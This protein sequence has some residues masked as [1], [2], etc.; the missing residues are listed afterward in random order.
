[1]DETSLARLGIKQ[2]P[3]TADAPESA[4][5][6]EYVARVERALAP[7]LENR[8]QTLVLSYAQDAGSLAVLGRVLS[9]LDEQRHLCARLERWPDAQAPMLQQLL[10]EWGLEA[11][12]HSSITELRALFELFV[13]HQAAKGRSCHLAGPVAGEP[14]D[15]VRQLLEW[16]SALRHGGEFSVRLLLFGEGEIPAHLRGTPTEN[17]P[18][19]RTASVQFPALGPEEARHYLHTRLEIAGCA[20]ADELIDDELCRLAGAYAS[21]RP[22]TL[23]RLLEGAL[24]ALATEAD[25]TRITQSDLE[26]AATRLGLELVTETLTSDTSPQ[27]ALDIGEAQL[28]M[29]LK[30]EP[31]SEIALNQSRMVMGREQDCDIC[32]ESRFISRFQCL[33]MLTRRGWYVMDLGSTNGTYVNARRIR[34]HLLR[35]GDMITIGRHQIL[36]RQAGAGARGGEEG[37]YLSTEVLAGREQR[38]ANGDDSTRINRPSGAPQ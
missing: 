13:S 18:P 31:A 27:Q 23:D 32:V 26:A 6:P 22:G 36:F 25:R 3:A 29:S 8:V 34:E 19:R 5:V 17:S 4:F 12:E 33:F 21:G 1:M 37:E 2:R 35:D 38:G 28:R 16:L 7:L 15:E 20:R 30:G 9:R 11:D 10:E 14:V 24:D